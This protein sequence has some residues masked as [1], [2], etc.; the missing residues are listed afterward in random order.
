MSAENID[1]ATVAGFGEEWAAFDQSELDPEERRQLFEGYF[2]VFPFDSLPEGAEGF[3]L[4]CGSGRWAVMVAPRVGTLHCIDPAASAL[5]VARRNLADRS[6]CRFHL[7]GVDTIPLADASQDF[8]Y[9]LGVLHHIP[10]TEAAMRKC[11]AK[12]KPRAPFLVYLYYAF[13]N[14][15]AWFRALWRV[16]DFGRRFISRLPFRAK[17]AVTTAIAYSVY[18]PLS[19]AARLAERAGADVSNFPLGGYRHFSVYT[20]KTDALDRFGTRLEHRFTRAEIE[21]MMRNC[22]LTDIRFSD[23]MPGWVAC[24]IRS[25]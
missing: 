17:R 24:G 5:A 3:D 2:S 23:R 13:D 10:D 25:A 7:A 11:V 15:P 22:G 20:L 21:A 1:P 18:Y 16:S 12:L 4:G 19:R 9:S 6:N 8:G 14:R